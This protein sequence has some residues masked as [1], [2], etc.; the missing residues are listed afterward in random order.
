M[1]I[2]WLIFSAVRLPY[3][4]LSVTII[5][6]IHHFFVYY[7][8]IWWTFSRL[9]YFFCSSRVITVLYYCSFFMCSTYFCFISR[10]VIWKWQKCNFLSRKKI[11]T[12]L[13]IANEIINFYIQIFCFKWSPRIFRVKRRMMKD[14]ALKNLCK[15]NASCGTKNINGIL[16]KLTS[17][18]CS[19][20]SFYVNGALLVIVHPKNGKE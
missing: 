9:F 8:L 1:F 4:F 10:T 3:K 14:E 15:C 6:K 2:C 11:L 16:R 20:V 12:S 13:F 17:I 5:I 7:R 19:I 18:S